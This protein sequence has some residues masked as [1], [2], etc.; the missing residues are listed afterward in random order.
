MVWYFSLS[1]P[2]EKH[3]IYFHFTFGMTETWY[4]ICICSLVEGPAYTLYVF[5][6]IFLL[7]FF[8]FFLFVLSIINLD[9]NSCNGDIWKAFTLECC[10]AFE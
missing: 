3:G 2:S 9:L 4:I 1:P 10:A 5:M 6:R 7:S 8:F